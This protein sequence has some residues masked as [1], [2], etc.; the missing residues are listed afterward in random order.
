M[1]CY[2]LSINFV[3]PS[4]T[5][6]ARGAARHSYNS[7]N[8]YLDGKKCTVP[9]F[10]RRSLGEGVSCT[11]TLRYAQGFWLKYQPR[12]LVVPGA[13]SGN[14][15]ALQAGSFAKTAHSPSL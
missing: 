12:V 5:L 1:T 15:P 6:L 4:L 8:L 14:T 7:Q 13:A 2:L 10:G 11:L 3:P 9:S